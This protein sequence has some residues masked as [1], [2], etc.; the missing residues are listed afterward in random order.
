MEEWGI[1]MKVFQFK[2]IISLVLTVC[3]FVSIL[4]GCSSGNDNDSKETVNVEVPMGRYIEQDFEYPDNITADNYLCLINNPEGN[5]ELYAIITDT[6]NDTN[7]YSRF[8]L[9]DGVWTEDKAEKLNNTILTDKIA[10]LESVFYGE[11]GKQYLRCFNEEYHT[12]LYKLSENG[13]YE[14]ISIPKFDEN[15]KDWDIPSSPSAVEVLKNGMVAAMYYQGE[16]EV[17]SSDGQTLINEFDSGKSRKMDVD[18]N[19]LYYPNEDRSELLVYNLETNQQEA[20]ITFDTEISEASIIE[21]V[22]GEVYLCDSAGIHKKQDGGSIWE[23]IIDGNLNSISSPTYAFLNLILGAQEDYYVIMRNN[24]TTSL[25]R[26]VY[27]KDVASTPTKELTIYSLVDSNT[28]RQAIVAYQKRNTDVRVTF[29]VANAEEGAATTAD[30]IRNLNT[31]LLAK[32]GADILVLDGLP[33]DSYIEKGVLE[34]MGSI[35]I[36][37]V[38]SEKLL[39]NIANNYIKDG[40]VYAM[41]IR[42]KMPIIYGH[43][44]AVSASASL[45]QLA[46]YAQNHN[47]L[48]LLNQSNYRALAEWFLLMNYSNLFNENKE[49][50]KDLLIEYLGNVKKIATN[51]DASDDAELGSMNAG[52]GGLVTRTVGYWVESVVDVGQELVKTNMEEIG[53]VWDMSGPLAVVKQ[54]DGDYKT[55]NNMYREMISIGINSAGSQKELAKEFVELLFSDEIQKIELGDGFPIN[56][57]ALDEWSQKDNEMQGSIGSPNSDYILYT[58]YPDKNDRMVLFDKLYSLSTPIVNDTILIDMILDEAEKCLR[59]DITTEQA[60]TNISNNTK[61][62]LAE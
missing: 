40:K 8:V 18:G 23:T 48:P 19:V 53:S 16:I 34:D 10:G 55:F 35:F 4:S 50:D 54:L 20:S 12:V 11:D 47:E 51:I 5:L 60:A 42:V 39:S 30:F 37:L 3:L 31:E 41:P 44:D 25:L 57:A 27:E 52:R 58:S 36:P 49:I 32:K 61:T 26:Y 62:Y 28:I 9:K 46:D 43:T 15:Y 14:M 38:E 17:Y 2:K 21:I 6:G 22:N 29:R 33:V 1:K 13:E 45:E 59:G 56:K 7:S 24:D